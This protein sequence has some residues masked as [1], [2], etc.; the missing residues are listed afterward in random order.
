MCVSVDG[1]R[2][3]GRRGCGVVW[4][5]GVWRKS[6]GSEDISN[7]EVSKKRIKLKYEEGSR[8]MIQ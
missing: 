8:R 1:E 5:G 4:C 3:R 2:D 6:E 7:M